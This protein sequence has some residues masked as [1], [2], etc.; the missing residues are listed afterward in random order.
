MVKLFF[1]WFSGFFSDKDG[2][3]SRK[4]AALYIL[5]F[6]LF[7][8]VQGSL[9]GKQIDGY[10]VLGVIGLI[11]WLLGA[12]TTEFFQKIMLQKRDENNKKKSTSISA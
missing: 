11:A 3:A 8:L 7:L 4:G 9:Q 2:D 1:K 6:F 12:I 10:I 5:L